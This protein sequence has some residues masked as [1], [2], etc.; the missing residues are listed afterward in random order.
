MNGVTVRQKFFEAEM[1]V[2][3]RGYPLQWSLIDPTCGPNSSFYLIEFSSYGSGSGVK[4]PK[5]IRFS[6]LHNQTSWERRRR[7]KKYIDM[8][9]NRCKAR[10]SIKH[11]AEI[12]CT[13]Y[14]K[15]LRK[16]LQESTDK[17]LAT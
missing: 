4:I 12:K 13:P 1:N 8:L 2:I 9:L 16:L 14:V 15:S 6:L 7:V 17:W 3:V 10:M 11:P 5:T